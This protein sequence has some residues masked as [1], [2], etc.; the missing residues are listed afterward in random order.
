MRII[1]SDLG[2]EKGKLNRFFSECIG[3]GRA[4]EVMR[5]NAYEQLKTVQKECNFKYIRFHGL[6]H[7][8]MIIV[9]RDG[10]GKLKFNFQYV[11]MLF[12]SLLDIGL[13]PIVEL[14]LMPEI[15]A[16]KEKYVFWWK[17]NISMPKDISEWEALVYETVKHLTHRYGE[18]EVKKWYFEVWN[19][20]NHPAFFSEHTDIDKYFELY[21]STARAVKR[22]NP[23]Y[24]VGGPAS[25]G[26]EWVSET[27][28]HCRKNDV[29]L[30]F[31]STH[32]YG[33]EGAFDSDGTRVTR[34]KPVEYLTDAIKSR[35]SEICKKEGYPLLITEWSSSYSP[36][37]PIHDSYVSAP[38]L[39]RAIRQCEG[40]ADMM[41]YWTYTD[42]FEEVG[43][44]PTP[45]HGG[46]GLMNVQSLKKPTFHVYSFLNKLGD[47][48]LFCDDG[49]AYA[50]RSEKEVQVLFWNYEHPETELSNKKYF[51]KSLPAKK[52]EDARVILSGFEREKA[53]TVSVETLGYKMGDVYNAFLDGNFTEL[54]TREEEKRL[55][56]MSKPKKTVIKVTSDREGKL[57]FSLPQS[58][59]QV[60][61]VRI[62]L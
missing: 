46:F 1:S 38:Y 32:Y 11:D 18:D 40:H 44:P 39:L 9:S 7:E 54:P 59:N 58:E 12:D 49:S 29:P 35:A 25:A 21:D 36:R 33:V 28:G 13:C 2:K 6:F 10:D 27:I 26:L 8:E 42:I 43:P 61:F 47:T 52:L 30:D 37:D 41:S 4:L 16:E 48:E 60:D 23:D 55:S 53:Y 19:E 14:G 17:M 51:T 31:I 20:P 3:A 45:F 56:K 50:C 62:S 22:V 34:L 15:M 5:H 57:E 24:R